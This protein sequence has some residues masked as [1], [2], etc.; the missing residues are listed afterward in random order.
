MPL[1]VEDGTGLE[2]ADAFLSLAEADAYFDD[3]DNTTWSALSDGVQESNIRYATRLISNR[4]RW[5]GQLLDVNTPQALAWPRSWA[6]DREGRS[7]TGVPTP[8][9]EAT[10]EMA[11]FLSTYPATAA[12]TRNE[13]LS[14]V[15]LDVLE[16]VFRNDAPARA[17]LP[18]LNDLLAPIVAGGPN[19]ARLV[20]G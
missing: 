2:S 13:T 19:S 15:T 5:P 1:T 11:V 7:L 16:V 10:A 4:Y 9:K 8:V 17:L 20:R 12:L 18:Y 3:R 14:S 6:Y